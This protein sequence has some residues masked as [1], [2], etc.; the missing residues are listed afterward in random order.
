MTEAEIEIILE[1][2]KKAIF[3][4][5]IETEARPR[6]G[7]APVTRR[8]PSANLSTTSRPSLRLRASRVAPRGREVLG[9][10][11]GSCT[12]DCSNDRPIVRR[13]TKEYALYAWG[14]PSRHV[15]AACWH[16][17]LLTYCP[18]QYSVEAPR[19]MT[20]TEVELL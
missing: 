20:K 6:H 8:P 7:P 3:S 14:R 1:S 11:P 2:I 4:S 19:G 12:V 18:R 16:V 17:Y 9:A 13:K 5:K 10:A 15:C